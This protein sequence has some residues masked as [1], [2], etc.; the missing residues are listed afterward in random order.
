MTR[1]EF[2][3]YAANLRWFSKVPVDLVL[4]ETRRFAEEE[5]WMAQLAEQ[6]RER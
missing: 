6:L 5:R 4:A 1:L 2:D 3:E